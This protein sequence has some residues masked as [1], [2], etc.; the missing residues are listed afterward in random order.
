[1]RRQAAWR[2]DLAHGAQLP[3]RDRLRSRRVAQPCPG[4]GAGPEGMLSNPD[5][6]VSGPGGNARLPRSHRFRFRRECSATPIAPLPVPE[7]MLGYPDRTASGS[8][9]NARLPRSHR[10]RSGRECSAT[11]TAP[12]PVPEGMLSYPDRTASG[13]GGNARLP[14]PHLFRSRR[15]RGT[16]A[17]ARRALSGAQGPALLRARRRHAFLASPCYETRADRLPALRFRGEGALSGFLTP[18]APRGLPRRL[19]RPAPR[20]RRSPHEPHGPAAAGTTTAAPAL[21]TVDFRT[22][23]VSSPQIWA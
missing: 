2:R 6:T 12:L 4:T 20:V 7:G 11:P 14:R 15:A 23:P 17:L 10:F 22:P 8:G 1:M 21:A 13:S 9:G 16:R 18:R 3:G 19:H 5:P